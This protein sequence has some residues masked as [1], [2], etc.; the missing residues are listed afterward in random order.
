MC[1]EYIENNED[2][3]ADIYETITF[4]KPLTIYTQYVT[5]RL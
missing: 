2:I 3:L 5:H 4:V 1:D